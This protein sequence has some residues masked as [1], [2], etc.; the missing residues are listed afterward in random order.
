MFARVHTFLD[1][2]G[3]TTT[4]RSLTRNVVER[5]DCDDCAGSTV[6]LVVLACVLLF[7][8][9]VSLRSHYSLYWMDFFARV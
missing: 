2:A 1:L 6:V 8:T 3:K 7:G 9:G 4:R 5:Y